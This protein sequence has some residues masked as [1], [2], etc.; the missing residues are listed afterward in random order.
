MTRYSVT[1]RR[2]PTKKVDRT[3]PVW[4]GI[5]C[6]LAL[7][8]PVM[9]W[10]LATVTLKLGL[11]RGWPFPYQLL[12]YPVMPSGLW[13]VPGLPPVLAFLIRQPNL[14]M[15][16]LLT[17]GYIILISAVLSFGYAFIYKY[18]GPPRYGPLDLPE[19]QVKVGRYK[20]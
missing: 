18:I 16:I 11:Q 6:L 3:P 5:G 12:G 15:L 7:V 8:V 20:R 17:V 9:S 19:P 1:G 4:R 14:Y 10:A 2:G 13:S